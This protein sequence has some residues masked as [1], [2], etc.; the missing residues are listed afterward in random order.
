MERVLILKDGTLA[1]IHRT[2]RINGIDVHFVEQ[3]QGPAILLL[4]GFPHTWASW[5]HQIEPLAAAGFRVVAPDL[6]GMGATSAPKDVE[7][8]RADVIVAD[9]VGLLDELGIERAVVSGLDF[10]LCAAY[11]LAYLHPDRVTATIGLENPF[12]TP[13]SRPPLAGAAWMAKKH[14]FHI[15]WFV[16][17]GSAAILNAD[18]ADFLQRLFFALSG[19]FHFIDVWQHPPGTSYPDALPPAPPLPWSWLSQPEFDEYVR[20]YTASGFD[21]G[22]NWYRAMDINWEF[23]KQFE[24]KRS[25]AP[26]YF[27]GSENDTDLEA[28]HGVDPLSQLDRFYEDVRAVRMVPKA[29]HMMQL[30]RADDVTKLMVEFL[31]EIHPEVGT[32]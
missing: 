18:P 12:V 9:L 24:G 15:D 13:T 29:G 8:Y 30:E 19:D 6:R 11:D 23:R 16:Q 2:A 3:G 25:S 31:A 27:I 21:G 26:F 17:P 4:H 7:S 14:F 28:F 10:G 20:A 22:L 1:E 32:E 5:R